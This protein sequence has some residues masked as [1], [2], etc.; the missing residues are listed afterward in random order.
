MSEEE[1]L[2]RKLFDELIK[3]LIVLSLPADYQK[4][5]IGG[6][7]TGDELALDF[8]NYYILQKEQYLKYGLINH[9]QESQLDSIEAF[10]DERS[11]QEHLDFWEGVKTHSDWIKVREWAKECLEALGKQD[12][13]INVRYEYEKNYF[14]GQEQWL[15][16]STE[17]VLIKKSS[18]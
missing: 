1:E 9:E 6:G 17:T 4:E 18:S 14:D 13:G 12:Y 7:D 11:G 10:F 16:H 2:V 15:M 8:E 3:H 5:Y